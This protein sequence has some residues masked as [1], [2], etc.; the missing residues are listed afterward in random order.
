MGYVDSV[1]VNFCHSV[2]GLISAQCANK[3]HFYEDINSHNNVGENVT[4]IF[5]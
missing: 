2:F 3:F 4:K 5:V 1:S